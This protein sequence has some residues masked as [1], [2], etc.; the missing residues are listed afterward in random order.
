V[1]TIGLTGPIASGKSLVAG[2]LAQRGARVVDADRLVH[3]VYAPGG[4]GFQAVIDA[5]GP[6]ISGPD[7]AIDR[8]RL[9]QLVFA[10]PAAMK[11]LTDIVWP[12]AKQR[13]LAIKREEAA[14]GRPAL[15]LEA[16]LLREAGWPDLVDEIWLVRAPFAALRERLRAHGRLSEA[17]IEAR[18]AARDQSGDASADVIIEND[19]DIAAL[20][21]QVEA[22]WLTL[23]DRGLV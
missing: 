3:D 7:G 6:A 8:R 19:G 12:L 4:D 13:F 15:V 10:D 23:R 18:I 17:E 11:R 21:R 16:A 2:L 9:G 22:A 1:I 14:A 5:F 20:T